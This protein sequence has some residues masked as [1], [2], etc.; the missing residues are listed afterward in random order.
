M[1]LAPQKEEVQTVSTGDTRHRNGGVPRLWKN[2]QGFTV[3]HRDTPAQRTE[4]QSEPEPL[5]SHATSL[6]GRRPAA[7]PVGHPR[8]YSTTA[9]TPLRWTWTI[10]VLAGAGGCVPSR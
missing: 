5:P 8:P 1:Q 7:A 3:Q 10:G 9:T 6:L 4:Q 2:H